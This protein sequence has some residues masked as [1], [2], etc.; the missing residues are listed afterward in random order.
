MDSGDSHSR[1]SKRDEIVV[2]LLQIRC[3]FLSEDTPG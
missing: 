2:Y 1:S 3:L